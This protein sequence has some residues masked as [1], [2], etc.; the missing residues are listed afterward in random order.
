M[1]TKS[2][3]VIVFA[4]F[5]LAACSP[6]NDLPEQGST[7]K[8]VDSVV[9]IVIQDEYE[10]QFNYGN[11]KQGMAGIFDVPEMLSL[12]I[13]DSAHL[14]KMS[15]KV[16]LAYQLL[17][18]D[19]LFVKAAIPS[20]SGQIV[21]TSD[22][23]N[24][25]FECF[26]LL[27][28]MPTVQPKKAKVVVLEAEKMLVFNHYGLYQNLPVAYLRMLDYLKKNKLQQAGAFREYYVTDPLQVKDTRKWLTVIMLPVRK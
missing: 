18:E 25:K 7:K 24:F 21:Y 10:Y 9:D 12:C 14:S 3:F 13:L 23:S 17:Q 26:Q 22:S 27:E 15:Q 6:A 4:L 20:I 2:L 19:L 11:Q 8:T 5:V 28:K 1:K 16:E